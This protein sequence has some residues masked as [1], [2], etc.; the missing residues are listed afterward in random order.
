MLGTGEGFVS[1][2]FVVESL[3][4]HFRRGGLWYFDPDG[5][6]SDTKYYATELLSY[7]VAIKKL[8]GKYW[9]EEDS[10]K[11]TIICK[12]TGFGAWVRLL[13]MMRDDDDEL[14]VKHLKEC[15]ENDEVCEPYVER[16]SK[17][18]SPI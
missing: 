4:R 6:I 5:S 11:G 7:F 1:Q 3:Q 16:V 8:F 14:M 17:I 10:T 18:L 12:T 15:A 13:G 2:A 9:P